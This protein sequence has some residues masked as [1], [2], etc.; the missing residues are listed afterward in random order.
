MRIPILIAFLGG[1][2]LLAA[3]QPVAPFASG[4]NWTSTAPISST[5][6]PAVPSSINPGMPTVATLSPTPP[7]P[8]TTLMPPFEEIP[9]EAK[10]FIDLS[11][12]MLVRKFNIPAAEV[13]VVSATAVTWRDASLG[14]PKPGIDYMQVETPG[15]NILLE[16]RGSTYSYHTDLKNRVVQCAT[17]PPGDIFMTP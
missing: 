16:A 8:E 4:V 1:M 5:L 7:S 11:I 3:C 2:L 14:C 17:R 6:I 15:Y 12:Q 9:P 10:P 13:Q